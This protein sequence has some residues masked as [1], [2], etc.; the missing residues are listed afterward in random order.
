MIIHGPTT[1]I[2]PKPAAIADPDTVPD[3]ILRHLFR[4]RRLVDPNTPC[5][6][7]PCP[8][9]LSLHRPKIQ[10]FVE[11]GEP[12]HFVVLAFPAKSPNRRKVLGP[13]PD[14]AEKIAIDFLQ[15]CCEHIGHFYPPG[16]RITICSDG[17][18]FGDLVGVPDK[19]VSDYRS[20]LQTIIAHTGGAIDQYT[21]DDAF[22][23]AG[24]HQARDLLQRRHATHVADLRRRVS[25]DPA[26]RTLFNGIHRFMFEDQAEI[27]HGISRTK[28]RTECKE[29]AYRVIQRSNAWSDLIAQ[30]FPDALRLSIHPQPPHTHKIGL[31][32]LRTRDSW[33]TPWHGVVVDTG[34]TFLLVKRSDAEAMNATVVWRNDRPSHYV[35]PHLALKENPA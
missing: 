28:L 8:M 13:L 7:E 4:F 35:A 16:A 29:L 12:V 14:M 27:R 33:L 22:P 3:R 15:A 19:D 23:G 5:A 1:L 2:A 21:L 18:V 30:R 34:E 31:H 25:S 32:L 9:C 17:H 24:H 6:T 11:K 20:A 26:A 10:A